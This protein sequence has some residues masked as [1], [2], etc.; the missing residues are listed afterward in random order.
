ME[1]PNQDKKVIYQPFTYQSELKSV[2]GVLNIIQEKV[3]FIDAQLVYD[4]NE[5]F[6]ETPTISHN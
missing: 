3:F 1:K 6:C 4:L 2:D 5:L